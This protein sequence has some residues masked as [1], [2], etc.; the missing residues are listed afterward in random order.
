MIIDTVV[1]G[2]GRLTNQ[3]R[4]IV[5][6]SNKSADNIMGEHVT[7]EAGRLRRKPYPPMLP[8]QKYVRTY[9]FGQAF[10]AEQVRPLHWQVVNRV[11]SL[12]YGRPYAVWVAKKGMQAQIHQNRWWTADDELEDNLPKLND[13]LG[14]FLEVTLDKQR[15]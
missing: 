15:D 1:K 13:K 6:F 10:K 11:K 7:D 2:M 5:E 9:R 12:R 3:F 8:G 4:A 14:G